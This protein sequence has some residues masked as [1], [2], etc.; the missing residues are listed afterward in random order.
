MWSL[1]TFTGL[2]NQ[3]PAASLDSGSTPVQVHVTKALNVQ[4]KILMF[5][6]S[7]NEGFMLSRLVQSLFSLEKCLEINLNSDAKLRVLVHL[8]VKT[9]AV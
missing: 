6:T 1:Q 8:Q 5:K 7:G 9:D 3:K 2:E 4:K